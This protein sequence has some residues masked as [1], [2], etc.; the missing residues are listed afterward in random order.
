M[1]LPA[2]WMRGCSPLA[3]RRMFDEEELVSLMHLI[4]SGLGRDVHGYLIG[5]FAM[6]LHGIKLSTK[7]I[8]MVFTVESAV[9]DFTGSL[10]LAGFRRPDSL[11]DE[12]AG[13]RA[14]AVYRDEEEHQFDLFL[15]TVC[16]GLTFSDGMR[17][18]SLKRL[19]MERAT[20]SIASRE[21]I[22]LFKG[23]TT[24]PLDIIDMSDIAAGAVDWDTIESELRSQPEHWKWLPTY[25]RNLEILRDEHDVVSP[26][27]NSLK[28]DAELCQ[29]MNMTLS[30]L[31]MGEMTS[32]EV[33]SLL[34]E[35]D[36]DFIMRLIEKMVGLELISFS[37]GIISLRKQI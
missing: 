13:L 16:N 19:E 9:A 14:R 36:E 20:I 10:E 27:L 5:G 23:I 32:E 1:T 26:T 22:F 6:M 35:E 17:E 4:D 28:D 37:G 33:T 18:R 24:R 15:N 34:R 7:D 30:R 25:Y 2:Y 11:S 29:A 8:D 3:E 31:E 21:D 12:Y